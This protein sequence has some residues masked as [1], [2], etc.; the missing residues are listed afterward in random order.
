MIAEKSKH[1]IPKLPKSS[2]ASAMFSDQILLKLT[3]HFRNINADEMAFM[4][5][6]SLET[7]EN[8]KVILQ[9]LFCI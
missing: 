1:C 3:Y 2:T 5:H 8:F 7:L 9:W 4:D 6:K